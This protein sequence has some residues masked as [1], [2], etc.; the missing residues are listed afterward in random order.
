MDPRR[1]R[2]RAPSA[3]PICAGPAWRHRLR[4]GA[5]GRHAARQGQARPRWSNR[6]R[7]RRTSMPRSAATVTEGNEA[8]DDDP[9][10]VNSDPEGAG[11]F[12]KLTSGRH[13][14]SSTGLMDEGAPTAIVAS[15]GLTDEN[16][17]MRYLPLSEP[18]AGDAGRHRRRLDRR[19][20]RRRARRR[21]AR[22]PDRGPRRPCQRDGGRAAVVRARAA[23]TWRPGRCPSSWAAAPIATT[24]GERRPSDPA[25]RVPDR[26]HALPAGN[27]AGHAAGA[28]RI[29]DAG[30]AALRL[31]RRQRLDV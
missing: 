10:L 16:G 29:P 26:L 12:F 31:R 6:S 5:R 19:S 22:R 15:A 28:V 18:T 2:H 4:R 9:A 25:R 3:S 8:L 13:R 23:A 1:G 27:R 17:P 7:P 24:P 21:P 30:R 14:A 20:F 11:W